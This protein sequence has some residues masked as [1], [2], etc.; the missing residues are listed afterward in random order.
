MH[1]FSNTCSL[2]HASNSVKLLKIHDLISCLVFGEMHLIVISFHRGGNW[3]GPREAHGLPELRCFRGQAKTSGSSASSH[4]ICSFLGAVL[5][6]GAWDT[7]GLCWGKPAGRWWQMAVYE[8]T[9]VL[10]RG[11][12]RKAGEQVSLSPSPCASLALPFLLHSPSLPAGGPGL[13]GHSC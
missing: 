5:C 2:L 8:V 9:M 1:Y 7:A 11:L 12:E 6:W 13:W 10:L 3:E 4:L